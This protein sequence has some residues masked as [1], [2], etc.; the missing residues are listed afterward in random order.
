[1]TGRRHPSTD[2]QLWRYDGR[3]R[4]QYLSRSR[5]GKPSIRRTIGVNTFRLDPRRVTLLIGGNGQTVGALR[6]FFKLTELDDDLG[7]IK[8]LATRRRGP[9]F[10]SDA[11]GL[12]GTR[13]GKDLAASKRNL[14]PL[15]TRVLVAF[16]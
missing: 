3:C 6:Q 8:G 14:I 1:M 16:R 15:R 2:A 12:H 11:Y 7:A 4:S 10:P 13:L 9:E 5:T